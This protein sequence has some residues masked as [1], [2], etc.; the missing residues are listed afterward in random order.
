[1]SDWTRED[2]YAALSEGWDIFSTDD[3]NHPPFELCAVAAPLD[4]HFDDSPVTYEHVIFGT[5]DE[6]DDAAVWEHVKTWASVGSPI[7][8]RAL[9]FLRERSPKEYETVMQGSEAP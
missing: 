6:P 4:W 9:F 3:V 5:D 2:S 1:M 8:Q 7:H